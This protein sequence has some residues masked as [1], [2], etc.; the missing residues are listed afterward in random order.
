MFAYWGIPHCCF[1][2][3]YEHLYFERLFKTL[4][5][6][7]TNIILW[8]F[9]FTLLFRTPPL[10]SPWVVKFYLKYCTIVMVLSILCRMEQLL[11]M[12]FLKCFSTFTTELVLLCTHVLNSFYLWFTVASATFLQWC[13]VNSLIFIFTT[14]ILLSQAYNFFG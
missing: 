3:Y 2:H 11:F 7:S 8:L 10:V 13:C 14:L 5:L 9:F 6:V 4:S 1:L 12:A